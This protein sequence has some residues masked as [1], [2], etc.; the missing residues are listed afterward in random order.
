MS[1]ELGDLGSF[2]YWARELRERM[3]SGKGLYRVGWE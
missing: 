3:G 2:E 1:L